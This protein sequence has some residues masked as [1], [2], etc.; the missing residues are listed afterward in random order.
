MPNSRQ[1]HL[2][3]RSVS[4]VIG[5][6]MACVAAALFAGMD[7]AVICQKNCATLDGMNALDG[8]DAVRW[9]MG[10]FFAALALAFT[11]K[12]LRKPQPPKR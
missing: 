4:V 11:L 1:Q 6:V 2:L 5:L 8:A 9:L 7:P 10:A 3:Q 12:G